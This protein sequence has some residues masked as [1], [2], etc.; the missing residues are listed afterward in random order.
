VGWWH[1]CVSN[2]NCCRQ[3]DWSPFVQIDGIPCS[4]LPEC[5]L[6]FKLNICAS[7]IPCC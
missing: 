7:T 2:C 6:P 4:P 1:F 5:G 3:S